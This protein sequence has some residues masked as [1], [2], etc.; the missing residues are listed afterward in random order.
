MSFPVFAQARDSINK[1][2]IALQNWN[3]N[4]AE[5]PL[6]DVVNTKRPQLTD[7]QKATQ[8]LKSIEGNPG[9]DINKIPKIETT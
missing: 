2:Y 5:I 6:P 7:Q 9:I 8:Y 4:P 1:A 3:T